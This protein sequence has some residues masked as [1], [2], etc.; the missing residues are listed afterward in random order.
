MLRC[1]GFAVKHYDFTLGRLAYGSL[2]PV[3][4]P[5]NNLLGNLKSLILL[6]REENEAGEFEEKKNV[7][8]KVDD[9]VIRLH[10]YFNRSSGIGKC[11]K[12]KMEMAI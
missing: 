8:E 6:Q 4:D 9:H 2:R 1:Q 7:K 10:I 3:Q 11:E 5:G 12:S